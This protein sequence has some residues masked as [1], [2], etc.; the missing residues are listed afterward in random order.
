MQ[1]YSFA[2]QRPGYVDANSLEA[3]LK[4]AL[5]TNIITIK[6][7][8][9]PE[10]AIIECS[11]SSVANPNGQFTARA[12]HKGELIASCDAASPERALIALGTN[13]ATAR[14]ENP[15]AQVS[16]TSRVYK[17]RFGDNYELVV[18]S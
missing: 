14:K 2:L 4:A 11:V 13:D 1:R 9:I 5:A 7:A 15:N 16:H 12:Y 3:A 6:E 8:K 10:K 18:K 17:Q